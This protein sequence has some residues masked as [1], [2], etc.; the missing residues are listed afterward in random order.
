[1]TL[2]E[3]IIALVVGLIVGYI[4]GRILKYSEV[5]SHRKDA[6]DRSRFV[7]RGQV[8]EKIAPLLPNFPYEASDMTFIGK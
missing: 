2:V 1:M 5:R 7:V 6:I 8:S 3:V 4:V